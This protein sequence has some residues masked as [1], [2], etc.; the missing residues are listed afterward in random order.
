MW[1]S[2]VPPGLLGEVRAEGH[3]LAASVPLLPRLVCGQ[4]PICLLGLQAH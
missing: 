2:G 4:Y 3:L 1:V